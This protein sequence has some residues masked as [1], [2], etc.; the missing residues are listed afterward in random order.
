[1]MDYNEDV[2]FGLIFIDCFSNSSVSFDVIYLSCFS[3][4]NLYYDLCYAL[5]AHH[6]F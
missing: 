1:M 3:Q 2:Q 5:S 4:L 6:L